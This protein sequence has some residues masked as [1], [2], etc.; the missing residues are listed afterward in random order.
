MCE[1]VH[2]IEIGRMGC[3]MSLN[4]FIDSQCAMQS[5]Y[6]TIFALMNF[7]QFIQWIFNE[8]NEEGQVFLNIILFSIFFFFHILHTEHQITFHWIRSIGKMCYSAKNKKK[9]IWQNEKRALFLC[10]HCKCALSHMYKHVCV[11]TKH[12]KLNFPAIIREFVIHINKHTQT[13][14]GKK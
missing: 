5:D 2:G 8:L 3:F 14:V 10:A 6:K 12:L 7:Q 1:Y 13:C 9:S 11:S 4:V